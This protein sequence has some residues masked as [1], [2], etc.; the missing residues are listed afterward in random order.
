[1]DTNRDGKISKEEFEHHYMRK[2][3]D[4]KDAVREQD[5]LIL[6]SQHRM[7][8]LGKLRK[9]AEV[10]ERM[11]EFRNMEGSSLQVHVHHA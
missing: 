11:N 7:R 9:E 8:D 2:L 5:F 10:S 1:M 6:E 3:K 4:L